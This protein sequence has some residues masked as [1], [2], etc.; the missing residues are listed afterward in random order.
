MSSPLRRGALAAGALVTLLLGA[1]SGGGTPNGSVATVAIA[2]AT[3]PTI[4]PS[5]TVPA[6]PT[7]TA[8]ATATRP[9]PTATPAGP[10]TALQLKPPQI[11]EG[12]VAFVILNEPA[13]SATATFRGRQYPMIRD[14][15]RWWAIVGVGA[16]LD[17]GLYPVSVSYTPAGRS[18]P[19]GIVAS[20]SIVK[21]DFPVVEI[22]LD[23]DTAALLAP[24]IVNA[25]LAQRAAIYSG[26]TA[27]RLWSGPFLAPSKGE[28]SSL[29]GEGR[30]YNHGPVTDY[31]RGTD[32]IGSIGAPVTAAAA[33]RVVFAGALRVRGNSLIVDHGAGVFSAYHHLSAFNVAEGQMV[34]AGQLIG[35]IGST[36][37]VTGPHLHWEVVVRGIEVDGLLWLNGTEIAP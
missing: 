5:P 3:P 20:L 36:G 19:V 37:L 22:D 30:S 15:D 16:L 6:P 9:P 28:L 1:C 14:G 18:T 10:P 32:F 4:V 31:H 26:Y 24:D 13:S 11:A 27:Q 29:F 25:E 17:A 23:P 2:P 33:G 34:T 8:A 35:A 21:G 12:G 7:V